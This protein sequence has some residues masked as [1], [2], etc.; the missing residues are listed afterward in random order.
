MGCF[1]HPT[2]E[3]PVVKS[4]IQ[5]TILRDLSHVCFKEPRNHGGR[6]FV[7]IWDIILTPFTGIRRFILG[8]ENKKVTPRGKPLVLKAASTRTLG[9]SLNQI[10]KHIVKRESYRTVNNLGLQTSHTVGHKWRDWF[11]FSKW[12]ESFNKNINQVWALRKEH[13]LAGETLPQGKPPREAPCS[14]N[15]GSEDDQ[16]TALV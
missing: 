9:S 3:T 10:S 12:K 6:S 4:C 1:V 15:R 14:V 2:L 16:E 8:Q 7:K 5:I 13:T 11:V